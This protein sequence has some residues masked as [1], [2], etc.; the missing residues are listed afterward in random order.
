M[1]KATWTTVTERV[2]NSH[3][4]VFVLEELASLTTGPSP[5]PGMCGCATKSDARM[6][7][8]KTEWIE[9]RAPS[10]SRSRCEKKVLRHEAA[11]EALIRKRMREEILLLWD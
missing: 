7:S 5:T 8:K 2:K 4:F 11:P 1:T 10:R 9:A 3:L 6:Q